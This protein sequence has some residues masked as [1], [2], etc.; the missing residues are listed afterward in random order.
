MTALWV[1]Y[2]FFYSIEMN[3]YLNRHIFSFKETVS[4]RRERFCRYLKLVILLCHFKNIERSSAHE[5]VRLISFMNTATA[6][7]TSLPKYKLAFF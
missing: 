1:G 3:L 6:R 5:N 7:V 2:M 4:E